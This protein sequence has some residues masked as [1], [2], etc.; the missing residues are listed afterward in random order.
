MEKLILEVEKN[1]C[2]YDK[3]SELFKDAL[4]KDGMYSVPPDACAHVE[5]A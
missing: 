5:K 2:L 4:K 3:S 1:P